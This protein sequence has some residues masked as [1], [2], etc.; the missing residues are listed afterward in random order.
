MYPP[1]PEDIVVLQRFFV[2]LYVEQSLGRLRYTLH[3]VSIKGLIQVL[4]WH[5]YSVKLVNF[6]APCYIARIGQFSPRCCLQFKLS[7]NGRW[8]ASFWAAVFTRH[9]DERCRVS[10]QPA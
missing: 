7:G 9:L 10:I 5:K 1:W 2:Y 4:V 8:D 3:D 6:Y